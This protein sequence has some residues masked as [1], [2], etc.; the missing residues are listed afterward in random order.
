MNISVSVLGKIQRVLLEKLMV[1]KEFSGFAHKN[2]ALTPTR[3]L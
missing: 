2:Y 1:F 3:L